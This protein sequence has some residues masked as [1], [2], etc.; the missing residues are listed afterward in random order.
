L[1]SVSAHKING[2][3]GVGLLYIRQGTPFQ[4]LLFG[5]SQE[6]ARRA[7][8]ENVAAIAAFAVAANAAYRD[9]EARR[10]HAED[11]REAL[12]EAL[13]SELGETA[14][15]LNGHPSLR[16]PHIANISFPGMQ[17][18][19]LLMNLDLAGVAASGGSAC[20]S[21][22]LQPS[23]VL[24]AMGISRERMQSAVRFSF[25]LGNTKE[26]AEK[27][28]KIIATILARIRIN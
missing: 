27:T 26:E 8:T 16:L 28:A 3:Q 5:G 10:R 9:M 22:S 1:L 23:H 14:F 15:H 21:G 6:R 24:A 17:T 11:V 13:R 25:G 18:D 12:L 19:S 2:P 7:G 4:A 20:T